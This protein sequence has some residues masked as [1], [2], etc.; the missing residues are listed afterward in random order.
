MSKSNK[1]VRAL[2]LRQRVAELPGVSTK[3]MFGYDCYCIN[4]KFFAGFSVKNNSKVIIK[5]QKNE[6]RHALEN[7]KIKPFS[8]GAK[9]GWIEVELVSSNG[10]DSHAISIR[11]A[12][13]W[14]EKSYNH[15]LN[16]A[17]HFSK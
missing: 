10:N 16:F 15:V 1:G 7:T 6:Q 13:S 3:K 9:S 4:G 17:N 8:N 2:E 5:L 14:I 12:Y 11:D